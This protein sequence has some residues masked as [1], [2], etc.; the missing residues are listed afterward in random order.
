[1]K[2]NRLFKINFS[3]AYPRL[4]EWAQQNNI[5]PADAVDYALACRVHQ[6]S[7]EHNSAVRESLKD[8]PLPQNDYRDSS[9]AGYHAVHIA[10]NQDALRIQDTLAN[11]AARCHDFERRYPT[12]SWKDFPHDLWKLRRVEDTQLGEDA[13]VVLDNH[14]V[15]DETAPYQTLIRIVEEWRGLTEKKGAA[16]GKKRGK[17]SR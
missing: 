5:N 8:I 16:R 15:V 10:M 7:I 6:M 17:S 14:R 13:R 3:E 12:A 9:W 4:L 1:M 2:P 11:T